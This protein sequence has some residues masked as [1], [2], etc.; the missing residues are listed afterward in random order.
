MDG[1]GTAL[2]RVAADVGAGQVQVL[3]DGLDEESSGLDIELVSCSVDG[4]GNVF[5]HGPDLLRRR[6]RHGSTGPRGG[7]DACV[8]WST[9]PR[10]GL[11]PRAGGR[12]CDGPTV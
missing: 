3:A 12:E 5:A 8:R 7:H 1:A 2:A 6:Q 4:Q 9:G 10:A 11:A